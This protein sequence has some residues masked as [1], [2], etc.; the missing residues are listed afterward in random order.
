MITMQM[1]VSPI[2]AISGVQGSFTQFEHAEINLLLP[3]LTYIGIN[4]VILGIAL[5]KFSIMGVI[6][7]TPLDWAG[8]ISTRT[9]L[10]HSQV[11]T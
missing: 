1:I 2:K 10:E 8:I 11:L 6:P 9:P 5:Y 3:K 7:V 4:L